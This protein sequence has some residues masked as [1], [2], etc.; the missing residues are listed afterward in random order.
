[1]LLLFFCCCSPLPPAAPCP[2]AAPSPARPLA[3]WQ[4]VG[5]HGRFAWQD[6]LHAHGGN[7]EARAAW[8][9]RA[10]RISPCVA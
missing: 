10:G 4:R 6:M 3:P 8:E 2:A 5:L 9:G 7:A 1:M